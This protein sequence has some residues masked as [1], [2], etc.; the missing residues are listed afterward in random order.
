M[1]NNI[2]ISKPK[3]ILNT[4]IVFKIFVARFCW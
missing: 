3:L 2:F 1:P 4:D